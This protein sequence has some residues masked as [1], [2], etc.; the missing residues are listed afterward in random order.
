MLD[1][2]EGARR[3]H[4]LAQSAREALCPPYRLYHGHRQSN[5][6]GQRE[7]GPVRGI[8]CRCRAG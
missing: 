7:S 3:R 6:R 5:V 4:H 2:H 8:L 1:L